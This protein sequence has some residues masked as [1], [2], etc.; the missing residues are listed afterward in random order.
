MRRLGSRTACLLGALLA[1]PSGSAVAD[2]FWALQL[3]GGGVVLALDS[4]EERGATI[5]FHRSPDALFSSLRAAEVV[6][7]TIA[8]GPPKKAKASLDG[9]ILV[10]GRDADPPE[11]T[12]VSRAAPPLEPHQDGYAYA[13]AYPYGGFAYGAPRRHR[14]RMR[15]PAFV[16]A[17]GF[18]ILSPT[19][20]PFAVPPPRSR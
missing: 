14:V 15:A 1:L 20:P 4:P 13:E 11:H 6:R 16:G 18:P 9:R 10:F 5:V 12:A 2:R 19:P 3:K 7:I 17:N 8:E